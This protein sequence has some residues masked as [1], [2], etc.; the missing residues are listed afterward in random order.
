MP[1]PFCCLPHGSGACRN[2]DGVSR[3]AFCEPAHWQAT[4]TD[5]NNPV[6]CALGDLRPGAFRAPTAS[7]TRPALALSSR[8]GSCSISRPG[9]LARS[10]SASTGNGDDHDNPFQCKS[11]PYAEGS[12]CICKMYCSLIFASVK[13]RSESLCST[14]RATVIS[15]IPGIRIAI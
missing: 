9:Q 12:Q 1:A 14:R 8:P 10:R 15:R 4:H 11:G 5:Q 13:D 6:A 3:A 7:R 2:T